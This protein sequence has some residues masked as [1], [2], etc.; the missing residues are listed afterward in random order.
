M[1]LFKS[2][3]GNE[4]N[5]PSTLTD[6]YAYFCTDTGN[7][8]I[9]HKNAEGT[10]VRSK[11]SANYAEKLRYES[12]G[13]EIVIEP[14]EILTDDNYETKIGVVTTTSSG[15]MSTDDKEK[16]DSIARGATNTVVDAAL[17]G[18]STNPVQNKVLAE[19]LDDK[20]DTEN[21][22]GTG[23]MSMNGD[24]W[25]AGSVKVGG[26]NKDDAAAK[27]LATTDV[28]TASENG[29]MATA[30][31]SKLDGIAEGA[32]KNTLVIKSWTAADM[33]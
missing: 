14:S 21:P 19:A 31:K 17:S 32:T 6:G 2:L 23:V 1:A 11:I 18:T 28:V 8:Y 10:L 24:A 33:A 5:L 16:L 7:F 27:T 9:D 29:L 4:K 13:T 20:L 22:T 12:D 25:F 3:R 30:D 26:S 15:L